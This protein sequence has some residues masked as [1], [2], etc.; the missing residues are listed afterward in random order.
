MRDGDCSGS[1]ISYSNINCSNINCS[2][3]TAN[4]DD[5]DEQG[6]EGMRLQRVRMLAHKREADSFAQRIDAQPSGSPEGDLLVGLTRSLPQL[7]DAARPSDPFRQALRERL[8][9][10]EV[11]PGGAPAARP[12]R[13]MG[14]VFGGTMS[15]LLVG[16]M[17]VA[18]AA[19]NAL[20]GDPLYGVKRSIEDTR[21]ALAR[22]DVSK[23]RLY[24]K[25]ADRRL[26][27][28]E[29]LLQRPGR[30]GDVEQVL[31]DMEEDV[32]QG[33]DRVAAAPGPES[34]DAARA[35]DEFAALSSTRLNQLSK[36]LPAA[37]SSLRAALSHAG[38]TAACPSGCSAPSRPNTTSEPSDPVVEPSPEPSQAPSAPVTP[39]SETPTPAEPS[40]PAETPTDE[41]TPTPS[42]APVITDA[43]AD[44]L[45]PSSLDA[46]ASP[47]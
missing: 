32:R 24:L 3:I 22:D 8:I 45:A 47:T 42:E 18:N 44:S 9:V 33:S 15:V 7:R 21:L 20:P 40:T 26:Q 23:G 19:E 12:R 36:A 25:Q 30:E 28:A 2:N 13:H 37:Q 4:V 38:K 1:N 14:W 34:A 6:R 39:P 5:R 46:A 11:Q 16:G 41:P 10:A 31:R 35:L 27:E 29:A 17:G 43:P